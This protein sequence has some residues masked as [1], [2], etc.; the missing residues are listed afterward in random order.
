MKA[1]RDW[2]SQR[3]KNAGPRPRIGL[4][5]MGT[6]QLVDMLA[7]QFKGKSILTMDNHAGNLGLM[8]KRT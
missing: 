4:E 3:S 8:D 7:E 5:E 2:M 1:L 6:G